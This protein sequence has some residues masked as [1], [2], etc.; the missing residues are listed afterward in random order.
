MPILIGSAEDKTG[1]QAKIFK[2]LSITRLE[3]SRRCFA[4]DAVAYGE[5]NLTPCIK[6]GFCVY[7]KNQFCKGRSPVTHDAIH[8]IAV[9]RSGAKTFERAHAKRPPHQRLRSSRLTGHMDKNLLVPGRCFP[10]LI[11]SSF[12]SARRASVYTRHADVGWDPLTIR[13]GP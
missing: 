1:G 6:K 12:R 7:V 11:W 9:E 10:P 2:A 3:G 8:A 5:S 13:R 4:V